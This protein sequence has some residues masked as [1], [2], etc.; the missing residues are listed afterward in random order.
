[1]HNKQ[2]SRFLAHRQHTAQSSQPTSPRV[3]AAITP[4]LYRQFKT[5]KIRTDIP[6]VNKLFG[7]LGFET[8]V[9]ATKRHRIYMKLGELATVKDR[10]LDEPSTLVQQFIDRYEVTGFEL[11][12][13]LIQDPGAELRTAFGLKRVTSLGQLLTLILDWFKKRPSILE[14]P[15]LDWDTKGQKLSLALVQ[16]AYRDFEKDPQRQGSSVLRQGYVVISRHPYDLMGMSFERGWTSCMELTA[17]VNASFV[18]NDIA[19]GTLV[20]YLLKQLPPTGASR[21]RPILG[22]VAR[23]LLKPYEL[24]GNIG[25]VQE[26]MYGAPVPMFERA[27][28]RVV[29]RLN[30]GKPSGVYRLPKD[31]YTDLPKVMPINLNDIDEL[32]KFIADKES[33]TGFRLYLVNVEPALRNQL[34]EQELLR[35]EKEIDR[36]GGMWPFESWIN[37]RGIVELMDANVYRRLIQLIV[38]CRVP[39][40]VLSKEVPSLMLIDHPRT[41]S[42]LRRQLS[43]R[44]KEFF[45]TD[46]ETKQ[47]L[48]KNL[49]P[50]EA[51]LRDQFIDTMINEQ[52]LLSRSFNRQIATQPA[53]MD[54]LY[55][56]LLANAEKWLKSD[57]PNQARIFEVVRMV[58]NDIPV[59]KLTPE[60]NNL[61]LICDRRP[62]A[63]SLFISLIEEAKP[64]ANE[65]L[66][67]AEAGAG[68]V[69]SERVDRYYEIEGICNQFIVPYDLVK[70]VVA[71]FPRRPLIRWFLHRSIEALPY[72]EA[73]A[74]F[75]RSISFGH[76]YGTPLSKGHSHAAAYLNELFKW[77]DGTTYPYQK[78]AVSLASKGLSYARLRQLSK[79]L[80]DRLNFRKIAFRRAA[81]HEPLM[82]P[83]ASTLKFV[84]KY[85]N[86][87]ALTGSQVSTFIQDPSVRDSISKLSAKE[88]SQ[89]FNR[90][91]AQDFIGVEPEAWIPTISVLL[92][93]APDHELLTNGFKIYKDGQVLLIDEVYERNITWYPWFIPLLAEPIDYQYEILLDPKSSRQLIQQGFEL[94]EETKVGRNFI[95]GALGLLQ[96]VAYKRSRNVFVN[97]KA[98]D[99]VN[100]PQNDFAELRVLRVMLDLRFEKEGGL[101]QITRDYATFK[102]FRGLPALKL[103]EEILKYSVYHQRGS[104]IRK[105]LG[106]STDSVQFSLVLSS[107]GMYAIVAIRYDRDL[108][109]EDIDQFVNHAMETLDKTGLLKTFRDVVDEKFAASN[110]FNGFLFSYDRLLAEPAGKVIR[111]LLLTAHKQGS[112]AKVLRKL[113]VPLAVLPPRL[114]T[115]LGFT[116]DEAVDATS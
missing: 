10:Q 52:W 37:R 34:F 82:K 57:Y 62:A 78:L 64:I 76:F 35:V 21:G 48:P 74:L 51:R 45:L 16:Q 109:D 18:R 38:K 6:E 5:T 65:M 54:R 92:S 26:P 22:P 70:D 85:P 47:A 28:N 112:L 95:K 75:A 84:A 58:V 49:G 2:R 61:L 23:I 88:Q 106:V 46:G 111:Q 44:W 53:F 83:T 14:H 12:T 8:G 101:D 108:Q 93:N 77:T 59:T 89:I 105:L 68:L 24:N 29:A 56:F 98:H 20:C 110:G 86:A 113:E 99:L 69:A 13:G 80:R 66:A 3:E 11:H 33:T 63:R 71:A 72:S 103:V 114:L 87:I 7:D 41:D 32:N 50:D 31:L 27:I 79:P 97:H 39:P 19:H 36:I 96:I 94:L 42:T 67:V 4:L 40:Q 102:K 116:E 104:R 91:F 1:M 60:E 43:D 115:E 30:E 90:F 107:L 15:D 100:H 9:A 55:P 17:G 25:W 81:F 73:A